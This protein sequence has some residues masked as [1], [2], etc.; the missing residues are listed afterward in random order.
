MVDEDYPFKAVNTYLQFVPGA[1]KTMIHLACAKSDI[2]LTHELIRLGIN[3]NQA[4]TAGETPIITSCKLFSM[5]YESADE[6]G[7]TWS[8]I[9]TKDSGTASGMD[10]SAPLPQRDILWRMVYIIRLLLSQ[11]VDVKARGPDG[12]T[13]LKYLCEA[14]YWPLIQLLVEHGAHASPYNTVGD[15]YDT[16]KDPEQKANFIELVRAHVPP[17]P[18]PPRCC[19]CWSGKLLSDCHT[20]RIP[21]PMKYACLCGHGKTYESCCYKKQMFFDEQWEDEK[22]RITFDWVPYVQHK[23]IP[24]GP[25][26]AP[27]LTR[28]IK[29]ITRIEAPIECDELKRSIMRHRDAVT[30]KLLVQGS[31]DPAWVYALKET[32]EYLSDRH[33]D[34]PFAMDKFASWS[35]TWNEHVDAYIAK[36]VDTRDSMDIEREA[37]IGL[38]GGALLTRCEREGCTRFGDDNC[39]LL[40]CGACKRVLYCSQRCQKLSWAQHKASCQYQTKITKLA[41]I[42]VHQYPGMF[43][44]ARDKYIQRLPSQKSYEDALFQVLK[45]ALTEI[46]QMAGVEDA[47]DGPMS[48]GAAVLMSVGSPNM[49]DPE[50][51]VKAK[52]IEQRA[53]RF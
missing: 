34:I 7:L 13:P 23:P 6:L 44:V 49:F 32:D 45:D 15:L 33:R 20:A 35:Y 46:D 24:V 38:K 39:R 16:L 9:F 40:E 11:H 51:R 50:I 14:G 31:I 37:K 1:G 5:M 30:D 36:G 28:F 19:P 29:Y 43:E 42:V 25:T 27:V 17:G 52:A 53:I 3:I 12:Q 10:V 41:E 21:Y 4:D 2:P 18:R 22:Q 47:F 48:P 26:L 8:R